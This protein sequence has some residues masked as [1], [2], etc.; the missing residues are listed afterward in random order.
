MVFKYLQIR[1]VQPEE[2]QFNLNQFKPQ[3]LH[4]SVKGK[5]EVT[6]AAKTD[7]RNKTNKKNPN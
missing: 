7:V 2:T 5:S 1:R 4:A 3:K 6:G